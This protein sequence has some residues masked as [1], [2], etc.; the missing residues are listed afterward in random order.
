MGDTQREAETQV[1]G[2]AGP[3]RERD[4]GLDPHTPGSRPE[5]KADAQKLSHPG[6]PVKHLL[7]VDHGHALIGLYIFL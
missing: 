1:E 4:V 3:H 2:A 6:V 5:S 7:K